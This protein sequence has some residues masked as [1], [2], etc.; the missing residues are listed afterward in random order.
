MIRKLIHIVL[1]VIGSVMLTSKSCAPESEFDAETRLRAKQDSVMNQIRSDFAS[2]YLLEEELVVYTEKARQKLFDFA[3]YL[4]L[5]AAENMDTLLRDQAKGMIYRLFF[6]KD[7]TISLQV[8][9]IVRDGEKVKKISDLLKD[10]DTSGHASLIFKIADMRTLE[11]LHQVSFGMY[12][13]K[14]GCRF[15]IH[16]YDDQDTT[17]LHETYKEVSILTTRTSKQFGSAAQ[18]QVWQVFLDEIADAK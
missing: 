9:A 4:N 1:A 15:S 14:L 12:A 10:I 6:P 7:A 11:P 8:E 16:A 18:V 5:Y 3:D 2:E 17:L 13:G